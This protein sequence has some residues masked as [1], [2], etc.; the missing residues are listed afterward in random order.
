MRKLRIGN[1]EIKIP[2]F[3]GGMGVGVSLS[4]LAS[5][6]ADEGGVGV[7]SA[8][9][10]GMLESDFCSD[11][12]GANLRVLKREIQKARNKTSG[13]IGV[14]LMLALTDYDILMKAAYEL[15]V[16]IVFAGAGLP[17]KLPKTVSIDT[18]K[19]A[20]TRFVPIVSSGRAA[21]L[22]FRSWEKNYKYV[23]D[24]VVVEGPKAGGHLGFKPS[25]LEF[26]QFQLEKILPEVIEAVSEYE[27]RHEKKI[28]V[29][30]AG[31]IHSG[32]DVYKLFQLGA[33]GAQLGSRFAAT[34]ECDASDNFKNMYVGS[35]K[36][37][38][39]IIK[40]PVGLPGRAISNSF[41][42]KV[43][44]GFRQKFT[45]PC[46]CLKSCDFLKA[47]YCIALALTNSCSGRISEGFVFAGANSYLIDKVITVKELFNELI[48][49][50]EKASF[51]GHLVPTGI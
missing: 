51:A 3:Q 8:T 37:D 25:D 44:A 20:H 46:R 43:N 19:N 16:D 11:F 2:I 41:L 38:L 24:A 40:S 10:I 39:R 6:V 31:G 29:I 17:L 12:G 28:P 21:A 5:A 4:G 42:E 14:N 30:A 9:G 27:E 48:E 47:P 32:E 36:E 33:S 22:I 26:P 34:K 35:T 45:C 18:A 13:V 15:G 50:F 23:P 49:G 7:I 1:I